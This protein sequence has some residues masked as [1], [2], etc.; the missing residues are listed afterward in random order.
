MLCIVPT[1][2][3]NLEDMTPRG[4]RMLAEADF[5]ACEDTR[6]SMPL[7]RRYGISKPLIAYHAFNE[8]GKTEAL[9][10]RLLRGEKGALI[11]DAGTPGISDPGYELI[12]RCIDEGVEMTALPGPTAF[13]PALIL[14]GLPP[15]PFL[16]YGF[17]PDKQGE[18][19]RAILS[20]ASVPWTLLFYVSPH[21]AEKHLLHICALLGDRRAA[22]VREISKIYEEA[23]RGVLSALA[24][25]VRGGVKGELVLVVEGSSGERG[26]SAELPEWRERAASLASE[27]VSSK[28]VVKIVSEEY[29]V[30]KNEVKSFLFQE[31][32]GNQ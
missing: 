29:S 3:G 1:P 16:F 17:L 19:E 14:S 27:G 30:P 7:L 10:E 6:T 9:V 15:Y 8:K 31:S 13:V 25:S 21:K 18:R 24:E 28:E 5:I 11:S 12:R 32:G 22:L 23:R 4:V 26:P 20:V 2:V